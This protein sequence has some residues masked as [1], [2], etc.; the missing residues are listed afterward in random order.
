MFELG[1]YQ[2]TANNPN[3]KL[4]PLTNEEVDKIVNDLAS[5]FPSINGVAAIKK[6]LDGQKNE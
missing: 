3:Y 5:K 1:Y 6:Q 4:A 2:S